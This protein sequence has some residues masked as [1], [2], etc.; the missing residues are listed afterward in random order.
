MNQP[1]MSGRHP[2]L[3]DEETGLPNRLHFDTVF[4]VVFATGARGLPLAILLLEI[5][6]FLEWARSTDRQEMS[7]VLRWVGGALVPVVRSTD[8]VA[9]VDESRFAF[10]LLDCNKAGAVLVADR[11]DGLLDEI[12]DS[13]GLGF[14]QGGAAYDPDMKRPEDFVGAAEA[15][16]RAAQSR[17]RNQMEFH[18]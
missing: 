7:R 12:R 3:T 16:L 13:T 8:L 17:G 11:I 14:S 1:H 2:A 6:G 15:G 18:R 10:C 5:D 9:R 4:E